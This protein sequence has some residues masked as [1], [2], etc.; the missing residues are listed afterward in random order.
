M[1]NE[2]NS[3]TVEPFEPNK[4]VQQRLKGAY[5][6]E[7]LSDSLLNSIRS[8]AY[9]ET[10]LSK[11]VDDVTHPY[12]VE[13][14]TVS[15]KNLIQ[16]SDLEKRDYLNQFEVK[17][18]SINMD[19]IEFNKHVFKD[20]MKADARNTVELG[21]MESFATMPEMSIKAYEQ[22]LSNGFS[23]LSMDLMSKSSFPDVRDKE[24]KESGSKYV[25]MMEGFSDYR[26]EAL[27]TMNEKYKNDPEGY[28]KAK[29]GL[30]RVTESMVSTG[31]SAI[32]SDDMQYH[33]LSD[34]DKKRLDNLDFGNL[35]TYSE[36]ES[37]KDITSGYNRELETNRY[38]I[39]A[40]EN[41]GYYM[42]DFS[43]ENNPN[44]K[45]NKDKVLSKDEVISELDSMYSEEKPEKENSFGFE[46]F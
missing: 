7:E 9:G 15:D 19:N 29:M 45:D 8:V 33:M 38:N 39:D 13:G 11:M 46:M 25:D 17:D 32:Y 41:E 36:F 1:F 28:Q 3:Q 34:K 14:P 37:T 2:N 24:I 21:A 23:N 27:D 40:L 18:N 6:D 35:N 43:P 22:N 30:D 4:E 31:Y 16:M 20:S 12:T 26:K 5:E 10:D 42:K 44:L